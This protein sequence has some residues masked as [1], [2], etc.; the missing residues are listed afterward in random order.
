MAKTFKNLNKLFDHLQKQA[1]RVLMSDVAP[2]AKENMSE[3]IKENTYKEY[4]SKAKVEPYERRG[5]EGGLSD[6]RNMDSKMISD[7]TLSIKNMT[8]GN[9]VYRDSQG[10][11]RGLIDAIIVYG[12]GYHWSHSAIYQDQPFPRDFYEDTI[13]RLE[14]NQEHVK[15]F[16]EGMRKLGYKFV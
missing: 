2:V 6:V 14:S 10:W 13:E 11:D 1:N 5:D 9:E 4:V 3:A 15:A 8:T 7:N 16:R 12:Q